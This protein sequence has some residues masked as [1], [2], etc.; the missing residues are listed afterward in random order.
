MASV[1]FVHFGSVCQWR[2][3]SGFWSS[4]LTSHTCS[5]LMLLRWKILDK[6]FVFKCSKDFSFKIKPV[7]LLN[8]KAPGNNKVQ[9][10]LFL[11]LVMVKVT[12]SFTLVSFERVSLVEYVCQ[13]WSLYLSRFKSYGQGL[14]VKVFLPKSDRQTESQTGN[15]M[16]RRDKN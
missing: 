8:T 4:F 14:L 11:V 16:P 1:K 15:S 5:W 12:S 10:W 13:I 9:N 2:L 6:N 3:P 7:C